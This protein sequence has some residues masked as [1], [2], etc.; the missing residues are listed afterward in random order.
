MKVMK[1]KKL[2]AGLVPWQEQR[3]SNGVGSLEHGSIL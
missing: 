1:G 2:L 3:A